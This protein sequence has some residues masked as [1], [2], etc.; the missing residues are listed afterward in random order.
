MFTYLDKIAGQNYRPESFQD[1]AAFKYLEMSVKNPN[2]IREEFI[3]ENIYLMF[4]TIP[5]RIICLPLCC[6]K[7]RRLK[8]TKS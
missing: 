7:S 2:G 1:V 5:F 8:Y 6:L 4:A 3:A